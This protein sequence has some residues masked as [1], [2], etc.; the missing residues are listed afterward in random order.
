MRLAGTEGG[1]GKSHK[2]HFE[3]QN[4]EVTVTVICRQSSRK[5]NIREVG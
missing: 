3:E 4:T 5:A 1:E 2:C